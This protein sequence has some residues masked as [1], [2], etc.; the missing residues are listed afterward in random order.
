VSVADHLTI[1]RT[2]GLA[3]FGGPAKIRSHGRLDLERLSARDRAA[4]DALFEQHRRASPESAADAFRYRLSR[5]RNG[6]VEAVEVP[7]ALLPAVV[8]DAVTDEL[9]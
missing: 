5:R 6:G 1:E 4:I 8:V 9:I 3:G 7:E 2:G